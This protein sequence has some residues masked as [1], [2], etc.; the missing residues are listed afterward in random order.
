MDI[1]SKVYFIKKGDQPIITTTPSWIVLR[2]EKAFKTFFNV[3]SIFHS[4]PVTFTL[5]MRAE[6][7]AS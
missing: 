7:G 4:L 2:K 5:F 3:V 1:I 6:E